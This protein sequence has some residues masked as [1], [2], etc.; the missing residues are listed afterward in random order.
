MKIYAT[1]IS[2]IYDTLSQFVG[3][4]V[5]VRVK[6]GAG[7][8][9]PTY[10]FFAKFIDI[11]DKYCTGYGAAC[12]FSYDTHNKLIA[13][14]NLDKSLRNTKTWEIK[15]IKLSYPLEMY[16]TD[17]LFNDIQQPDNIL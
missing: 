15:Y 14:Y 2:D 6:Y 10:D 16:T 11:N 8:E 1:H 4:D 9:Y 3:E 12:K 13:D 7:A 17:E 5:W